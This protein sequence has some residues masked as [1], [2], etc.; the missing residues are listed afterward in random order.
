MK[1]DSSPPVVPAFGGNFAKP[2]SRRAPDVVDLL[3]GNGAPRAPGRGDR[4]LA[5]RPAGKSPDPLARFAEFLAT[6]NL[7]LAAGYYV[8]LLGLL[9]LAFWI[10]SVA[11]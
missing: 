3:D 7:D 1:N 9:A 11:A 4:R 6:W 5:A 10:R 2:D 8:A